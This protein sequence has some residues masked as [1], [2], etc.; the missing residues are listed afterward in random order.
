MGLSHDSRCT[1]QRCPQSHV[2][3]NCDPRVTG[4]IEHN[5][6]RMVLNA[7]TFEELMLRIDKLCDLADSEPIAAGKEWLKEWKRVEVG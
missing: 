2:E 3:H 5:M 6:G 4:S 7:H 1:S